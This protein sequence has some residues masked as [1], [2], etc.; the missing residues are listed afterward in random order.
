[1]A[2]SGVDVSNLPNPWAQTTLNKQDFPSYVG[3]HSPKV[4]I[5]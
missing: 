1:M 5:S 2:G 4:S 3:T